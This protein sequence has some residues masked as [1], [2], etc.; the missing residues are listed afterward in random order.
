MLKRPQW[1]LNRAVVQSYFS[2][3][4]GNYCGKEISFTRRKMLNIYTRDVSKDAT[5]VKRSK[6]GNSHYLFRDANG[7][8]YMS[9]MKNIVHHGKYRDDISYIERK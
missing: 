7:E 3:F 6:I 1:K 9:R 5:Y 2:D 4:V 8:K